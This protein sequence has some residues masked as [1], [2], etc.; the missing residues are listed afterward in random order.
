M[1][2]QPAP[3]SPLTRA[4][5]PSPPPRAPPAARRHPARRGR[6]EVFSFLQPRYTSTG[7]NETVSGPLSFHI[8]GLHLRFDPRGSHPQQISHPTPHHRPRARDRPRPPV[9]ARGA[10]SPPT[11]KR[12]EVLPVDVAPQRGIIMAASPRYTI[13]TSKADSVLDWRNAPPPPPAFVRRSVELGGKPG[14]NQP[15][16]SQVRAVTCIPPPKFALENLATLTLT[17]YLFSSSSFCI[18]YDRIPGKRP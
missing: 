17:L 14:L 13:F 11:A 18:L 5:A 10:P 7:A 15:L 12:A 16:D 6:S 4:T 2:A 8:R 3:S 9:R 1:P